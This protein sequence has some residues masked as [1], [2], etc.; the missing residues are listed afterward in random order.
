MVILNFALMVMISAL[1][2]DPS[3]AIHRYSPVIAVITGL[4]T[5]VALVLANINVVRLRKKNNVIQLADG[6]V[7]LITSV[8]SILILQTSI[9]ATIS[10]PQIDEALGVME[11]FSS[12]TGTPKEVYLLFSDTFTAL[13]TSNDIT[14]I[15]VGVFSCGVTGYM[16]VKGTTEKRK[17]S[18]QVPAKS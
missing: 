1:I 7:Q 3:I 14:G 2:A 13:V 8:V 4:W 11:Q 6:F 12:V 16:I 17:V 18:K 15:I 10:T 9:I 5:V